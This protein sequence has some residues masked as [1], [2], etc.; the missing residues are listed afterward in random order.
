MDERMDTPADA[1]LLEI[2]TIELI[3]GRGRSITVSSVRCPV[4][5]RSS[6]VEECSHC[7][8]SDG[9]AQDAMA[10]GEWVCCRAPHE[11]ELP[12]AG[13][14]VRDVMPAS[15]VAFRPGV[16]RSIAADALRV[17]RQ[18]SAPVVDGEGRPIGIVGEAE[19][20]RARAGAKVADA[21]ARVAFAVG[22]TA[23]L[24]RAAALMA[25]HGLDRV[26]VVS[27]DGQVVGVLSAL[28]LVRWI[29]AAGGSLDPVA[30]DS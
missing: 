27:A 20:L 18:G 25:S 24:T 30:Y 28:D 14:R 21:M 3:S 29:A 13:A 19:L 11:A 10:R 1:R 16:G 12:A 5:G 6:A 9:I 8:R 7:G 23:P 4:R 17:R 26:A 2:R 22:E 15:A